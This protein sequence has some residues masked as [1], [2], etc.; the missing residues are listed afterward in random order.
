M[1]RTN[2]FIDHDRLEAL[3]LVAARENSNVSDLIRQAIDVI[4]S[5]RIDNPRSAQ[6][7]VSTK[8]RGF[9][10]K[11]SSQ[12][13][14]GEDEIDDLIDRVSSHRAARRSRGRTPA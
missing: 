12:E 13:S 4:L 7:D 5:D 2:F 1:K 10:E 9:L 14:A 6:I 3:K 8:I 11:Y